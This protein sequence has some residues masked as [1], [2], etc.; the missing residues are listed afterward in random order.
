MNWPFGNMVSFAANG[1]GGR[2]TLPGNATGTALPTAG[3][4]PPE[5]NTAACG[6]IDVVDGK[7]NS[8]AAIISGISTDAIGSPP[9]PTSSPC[10]DNEIAAPAAFALTVA[11]EAVASAVVS[12]IS[13]LSQARASSSRIS[14]SSAMARLTLASPL[15]MSQPMPIHMP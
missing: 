15:A 2:N 11:L 1:S 8:R 14:W 10:P 12:A 7:S 6:A 3:A 5:D 9:C 13:A 4:A